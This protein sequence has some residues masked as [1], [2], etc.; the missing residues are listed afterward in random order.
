MSAAAVSGACVTLVG[1]GSAD[2]AG[3]TLVANSGFE[4]GLSGWSCADG[5]GAVVS[6]PAHSGSSA[7]TA[8]PSGL[9]NAQCTQT[10]SVQPNS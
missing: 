1:S 8:T 3:T 2:A 10:V 5:S 4:S 7:L 9:G 6:S